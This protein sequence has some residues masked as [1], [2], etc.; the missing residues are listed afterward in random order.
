MF[1]SKDTEEKFSFTYLQPQYSLACLCAK[2][3]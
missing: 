3:D 1:R 2:P